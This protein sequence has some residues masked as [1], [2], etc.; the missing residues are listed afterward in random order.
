MAVGDMAQPRVGAAYGQAWTNM[1]PEF[2]VLVLMAIIS[3][4]GEI[5]SS[6]DFFIEF[7][8]QTQTIVGFVSLLL[9]ILVFG[10][11][12]IGIVKS[13]LAVSRGEKANLADLG[14]GFTRYGQS[15]L[16]SLLS[17]LIVV[18]GLILLIIPG[19]YFAV[20]LSFATNRFVHDE[21]TAN[22]AIRASFEDVKGHWWPTFGLA[23]LA[24]LIAIGGLITLIFGVL[25][26]IVWVSQA[27]VVYW[28]AITEG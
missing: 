1:W 4:V 20:K 23:I 24:F 18:G 12:G 3:M 19:I 21:M 6:G 27:N 9:S 13:H 22:D 8:W 11:L 7:G 10:P 17:F 14:Y 28:R 5:V 16:L 25:V 2:W 26:A 15:V